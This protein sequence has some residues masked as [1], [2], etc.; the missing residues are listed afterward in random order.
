MEQARRPHSMST[1]NTASAD[2][3]NEAPEQR[4]LSEV[5]PGLKVVDAEGKDLGKVTDLRMGS[6]ASVSAAGAEGP[7]AASPLEE[8]LVG[9]FGEDRDIPETIR[10]R[11]LHEGFIK[12]G[13]AGLL[14]G[15]TFA[16]STE[17]VAVSAD[18]VRLNVPERDLIHV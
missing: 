7:E 13:G 1:D 6:P 11:M 17:I 14:G 3:M 15:A 4:R 16:L 5:Q 10:H 8:V 9:W 2:Y 18:T 12:I